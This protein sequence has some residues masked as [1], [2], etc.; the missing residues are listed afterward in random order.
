MSLSDHYDKVRIQPEPDGG[1]GAYLVAQSSG[2][3]HLASSDHLSKLVE[4]DLVAKRGVKTL[5]Q[6]QD[7]EGKISTN[8]IKPSGADTSGPE[9][10]GPDTLEAA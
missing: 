9:A 7:P 1:Y 8:W 2:L 3:E 10:D 6:I 4:H 5:V